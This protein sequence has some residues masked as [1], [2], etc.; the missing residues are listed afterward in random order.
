MSCPLLDSK[1]DSIEPTDCEWRLDMDDWNGWQPSCDPSKCFCFDEGGP[2][3]NGFVHCC[4]CGRP[5]LQLV[6][7]VD[8][9]DNDAD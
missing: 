7:P 4:Y 2:A 5:L 1:F 9:E 8:T 3:E 6:T